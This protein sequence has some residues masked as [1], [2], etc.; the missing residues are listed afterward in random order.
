MGS[1]GSRAG[2][3]AAHA[4]PLHLHLTS[5]SPQQEGGKLAPV[6]RLAAD[7]QAASLFAQSAQPLGT[8]SLVFETFRL[9]KHKLQTSQMGR[10]LTVSQRF[11]FSN[12]LRLCPAP[13]WLLGLSVQPADITLRQLFH[14]CLTSGLTVG[15]A[16]LTATLHTTR[17]KPFG[18]AR[19]YQPWP[20]LS[21]VQVLAR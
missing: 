17:N 20:C 13:H 8:K 6:G 16:V 5:Y 15:A 11:F 10:R 21:P 14:S 2:P 9:R 18:S 1:W 19:R 7:G 12:R 3:A 4:T